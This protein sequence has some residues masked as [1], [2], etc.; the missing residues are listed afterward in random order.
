MPCTVLVAALSR[1][2]LRR[3]D[4]KLMSSVIRSPNGPLSFPEKSFQKR[5]LNHPH[6]HITRHA[7][8]QH[9]P[10]SRSLIFPLHPSQHQAQ[11][12]E[13]HAQTAQRCE[14]TRLPIQ[15]RCPRLVSRRCTDDHRVLC[16]LH[17]QMHLRGVTSSC[18]G[19]LQRSTSS[20]WLV[21][22]MMW[23]S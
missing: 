6:L 19:L 7:L 11:A 17:G 13:S 1:A 23:T 10:A 22:L 9:E 12:H 18:V 2:L 5:A 14:K 16:P 8:L 20:S 15:P 21:I 4:H 3:Y